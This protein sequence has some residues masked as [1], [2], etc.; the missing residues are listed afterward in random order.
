MILKCGHSALYCAT[1]GHSILN[2]RNTL[3]VWWRYELCDDT[4][5]SQCTLNAVKTVHFITK[6]FAYKS[7]Y[8]CN[9]VKYF[10]EIIVVRLQLLLEDCL[11]LVQNQ[12]DGSKWHEM[13][14]NYELC[15]WYDVMLD[16]SLS[17]R[18]EAWLSSNLMKQ[19]KLLCV[20]SVI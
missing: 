6:Y 15:C 16:V 14:R 13:S 4:E 8:V 12:T 17:Q 3:L 7:L 1:Q 9:M 5:A 11:F 2:L 19:Y 20:Y 10:V 18:L